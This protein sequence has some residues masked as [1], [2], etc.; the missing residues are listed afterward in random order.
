M[1]LYLNGALMEAGEAHIAPGDRGFTLGDGLFETLRVRGG[2]LR[3]LPAHL[4]RLTRGAAVLG[5]PLPALDFGA[6]L[7]QVRAANA[8]DDGVLRLTV[9]RGSGPRGVLPPAEPHPTVLITAAPMAPPPPPARLII[10]S[11]TRRNER[12]P[13]SQVK[14]LNYLD[15]I[16]ARQEAARAGADDALLLNTRER[17]AESTIANLFAVIDGRLVTPPVSEGALPGVMR[18]AVKAQGAEERPLTP[19][20]LAQAEEIFL[21]SS[22]GIRPVARLTERAFSVFPVAERLAAH[23]GEA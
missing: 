11:V 18:A 22:L 19:D 7:E 5:L 6:A 16:L 9:T 15:N 23:L 20:D 17:L 14:S 8:L 10:A 13:L 2:F 4:A 1:K 3:R 21:T 12:S